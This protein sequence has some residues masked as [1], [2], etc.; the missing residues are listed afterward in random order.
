[1]FFQAAKFVVTCLS[2]NRKLIHILLIF[3]KIALVAFIYIRQPNKNQSYER[4]RLQS[5]D[6]IY[7][8]MN[9]PVHVDNINSSFQ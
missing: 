9:I 5:V 4:L 7:T 8:I 6:C 1:M 3:F 2:S